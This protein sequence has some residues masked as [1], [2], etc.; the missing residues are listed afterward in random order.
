MALSAI[1][2]DKQPDACIGCRSCEAVCPQ[3]IK[4]SEVMADFVAR[5]KIIVNICIN[6]LNISI[7]TGLLLFYDTVVQRMISAG[8]QT[9]KSPVF[10]RKA[11]A[12]RL[13][14]LKPVMEA[15]SETV[16]SVVFRRCV[17]LEI[18]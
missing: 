1:P 17:P 13:A 11:A 9:G 18:R 8:I 10:V 16:R 4:I 6:F 3:Q 2:E 5:L 14:L 15:I 12:K 7:E